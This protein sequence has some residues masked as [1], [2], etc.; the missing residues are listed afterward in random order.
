MLI[1][2]IIP[3]IAGG[4]VIFLMQSSIESKINDINKNIKIYNAKTV[5]LMPQVEKVNAL[6]AKDA[7]IFS[8]SLK[9]I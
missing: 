9:F 3:V 2:L 8:A 7:Q 5:V 4:I 6:K 1:F